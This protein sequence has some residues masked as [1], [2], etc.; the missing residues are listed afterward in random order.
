MADTA[1]NSLRCHVAPPAALMAFFQPSYVSSLL[2]ASSTAARS[3]F[4]FFKELRSLLA[5]SASS[6]SSAE[7]VLLPLQEVSQELVLGDAAVFPCVIVE[8]RLVEFLTH[9]GRA[10]LLVEAIRE[11]R[12]GPHGE[13]GFFED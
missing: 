6:S 10:R 5:L 11:G 13:G 7:M 8:V 9:R 4:G 3:T 12:R 2:G 1:D